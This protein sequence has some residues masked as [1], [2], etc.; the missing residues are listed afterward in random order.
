MFVLFTC[1]TS[2][3]CLARMLD[4]GYYVIQGPP[5]IPAAYDGLKE[6][7]VAVV[8]VSVANSFGPDAS[9][10]R[11]SRELQRLLAGKITGIEVVRE[12]EVA[13][14]LDH[15]DWTNVDYAELGKGVNA[16][17][18]VVVEL[19]EPLKLREGP[20]LYRGSADFTVTVIDI[21]NNEEKVFRRRND[22]FRWPSEARYGVT[23][24]KFEQAFTRRVASRI[25]QYFYGVEP[26]ADIGENTSDINGFE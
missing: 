16:D 23:E 1:L 22:E 25:G 26:N 14:W 11:I 4:F 18:V 24:S 8:C 15:N 13:D 6:K 3:G 2:T 17:Q 9:T 20:T 12:S 7:R 10:N 21:K 5:L 19:N